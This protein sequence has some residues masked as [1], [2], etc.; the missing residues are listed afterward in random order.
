[1]AIGKGEVGAPRAEEVSGHAEAIRAL[2]AV[3]VTT[4]E[5]IWNGQEGDEALLRAQAET[6][7]NADALAAAQRRLWARF[8]PQV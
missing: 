2:A 5:R 7:Q 6:A 3:S 8:G 1:M 4:Q